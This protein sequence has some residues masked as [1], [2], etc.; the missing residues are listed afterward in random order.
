[1]SK[2]KAFLLG[3]SNVYNRQKKNTPLNT[4]NIHLLSSESKI[5]T[6]NFI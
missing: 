4:Q 2:I 5:Q 6:I 1:M 3:T